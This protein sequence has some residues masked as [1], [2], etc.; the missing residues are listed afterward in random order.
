MPMETRSAIDVLFADMDKLSPGDDEQTL[1]V[2]R[3][4][5]RRRFNVV[6]DAGCGV[7]RQT[8]VLARELKTDIYAVDSH[9]PFL[10]RLNQR[11][12]QNGLAH[13]VHTRLTDMT[14]IPYVFPSIDLLWSEGAAYNIGFANALTKWAKAVSPGGF[15][16][17]SELCWLRNPV[18]NLVREFFRSGYPDMKSVPENIE[19]AEQAG[20]E[21]FNIYTL[22]E[23]AWIEDYYEILGSRAKSLI[24][25]TDV[26]VRDLALETIKEID[27]FRCS[28]ET[29]GYV[30]FLLRRTR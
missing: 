5:P 14:D 13:L 12:E 11:A 22:P 10:D 18:P 17:V 24:T 27:A 25:H 1:Y 30:F 3:S 23:K 6:V 15:A 29:Y 4:V 16:V 9:Q 2:L 21:I 26:A 19:I 7:G 20:Y 8:F 28:E